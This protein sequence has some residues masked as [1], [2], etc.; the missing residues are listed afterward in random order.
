[1]GT[2]YFLHKPPSCGGVCAEHCHGEEIHLGKSSAGWSFTFQAFPDTGPPVMDFASWKA[3]LDG[4]GEIRDEY[5][6]PVTAQELLDTVESKRGG[7]S[8]L[9]P[10]HDFLDADGNR[11]LKGDFS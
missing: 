3:Q 5:G 1:M 9:Y 4:P 8:T 11:F 7:R 10:P 6:Q 2:N